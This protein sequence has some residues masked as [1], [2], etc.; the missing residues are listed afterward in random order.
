MSDGVGVELWGDFRENLDSQRMRLWPEVSLVVPLH[1]DPPLPQAELLA[2]KRVVLP[3]VPAIGEE[4]DVAN[5]WA[6]VEK[7]R[8]E[9]DRPA[10]VSLQSLPASF[11]DRL[12]ADGFRVF[13]ARDADDSLRRLLEQ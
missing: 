12:E 7:V 13:P 5:A 6:T 3:R 4:C 2:A 10:V 9:R 1:A 11:A 8:W